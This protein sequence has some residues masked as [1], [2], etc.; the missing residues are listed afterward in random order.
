MA[1]DSG[2]GAAAGRQLTLNVRL[3]DEATLGNFL[4]LPGLEPLLAALAGLAGGDGDSSLFLHGPAD[5]GRTHLL[6]AAC[7]ACGGS[8]LYLPL[9]EMAA[10]PAGQVLQDAQSLA[11][12]AVDDLQA[13]AGDRDWELALFNLFNA[14]QAGG[15]RLVFAADGAPA[16]LGV[17][18]A[19]LRSRLEWGAVFRLPSLSDEQKRA[20]FEFRASRR[21]LRLGPETVDY[22]FRRAPRDLNSLMNLLETLDR[23]SLTEQRAL[24][25]PFVREALGW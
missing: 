11:L 7:H 21:G 4:P 12:V 24:S 15:S 14:A 6:Q 20:I 25:I 9:R 17:A 13:V 22:L 10:Y 23:A 19:D 5:S 3:R 8:A 2:R 18:L 1:T 16:T